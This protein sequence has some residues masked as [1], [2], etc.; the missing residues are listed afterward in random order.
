MTREGEMRRHPR[1][2]GSLAAIA[3]AVLMLTPLP[4]LAQRGASA[5]ADEVESPE[6]TAVELAPRSMQRGQV[7]RGQMQRHQMQQDECARMPMQQGER[8]QV[9]RARRGQMQRQQGTD[10]GMRTGADL[11]ERERLERM[12][13]HMVAGMRRMATRLAAVQDRILA[14]DR[15]DPDAAPPVDANS[16]GVDR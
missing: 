7:Q 4:A 8:G 15:G 14:L 1:K 13:Q 9:Q 6:S 11:T 12:R 5:S 2:P 10:Q 3:A 16:E